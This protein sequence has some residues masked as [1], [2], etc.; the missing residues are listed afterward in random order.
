MPPKTISPLS[1]V[2]VQRWR[3]TRLLEMVARDYTPEELTAELSGWLA[4]GIERV[5]PSFNLADAA[6]RALHARTGAGSGL[7]ALLPCD[8]SGRPSG[9]SRD[10]LETAIYAAIAPHLP[11]LEAEPEP[12]RSFQ[13][14][15]LPLGDSAACNPVPA[16]GTA[17]IAE[18][19]AA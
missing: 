5:P 2:Q 11:Q 19:W 7:K 1:L 6:T 4:T 9:V 10:V 3:V 13:G 15:L 17:S 16:E 18:S 14:E 12:L 8:E